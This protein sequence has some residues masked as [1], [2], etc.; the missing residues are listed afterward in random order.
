MPSEENLSSRQASP[1]F[2]P[3]LTE[4]VAPPGFGGGG[5]AVPQTGEAPES[6]VPPAPPEP[7]QA[8]GLDEL[9]S[10]LMARLG[11]ELDV[12]LSET[13]AQVMDEQMPVLT[14]RIRQAVAELVRQT[15]AGAVEQK[16]ES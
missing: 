2:V 15:V 5:G 8:H 9:V 1:R 6:E 13:I 3:T 4:I 16:T 10:E 7:I 12:K 14:A 11:P